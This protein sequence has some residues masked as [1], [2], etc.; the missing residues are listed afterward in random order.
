[1]E[2]P[3]GRLYEDVQEQRRVNYAGILR[4]IRKGK[5]HIIDLYN[6]MQ[7]APEKGIFAGIYDPEILK[8]SYRVL[9]RFGVTDKD[10]EKELA[11]IIFSL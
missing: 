9:K 10:L 8:G 6:R 11:R 3:F 1:M 4:L 7:G 2:D 5:Q